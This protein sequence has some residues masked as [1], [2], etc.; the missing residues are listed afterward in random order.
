[1][2]SVSFDGS[3]VVIS[4]LEMQKVLKLNINSVDKEIK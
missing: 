3:I 2:I 4:L 1:M